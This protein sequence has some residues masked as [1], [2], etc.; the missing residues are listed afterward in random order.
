MSI[1]HDVTRRRNFQRE[2]LDGAAWHPQTRPSL[3]GA[4][5]DML[6]IAYFRYAIVINLLYGAP[7]N[8]NFPVL[9]TR[10]S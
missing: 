7:K 1:E 6:T 2:R 3:A 5:L 8:A 9:E 4:I 10:E